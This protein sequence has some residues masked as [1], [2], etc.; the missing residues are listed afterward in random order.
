MPDLRISQLPD[1]DGVNGDELV[2]VVQNGLTVKM[3][4]QQ[5]ADLAPPG[6]SDHIVAF[7]RI[8]QT[9]SIDPVHAQLRVQGVNWDC[10]D[11]SVYQVLW[12]DHPDFPGNS[13]FFSVPVVTIMPELSGVTVG[14]VEQFVNAITVQFFD[15]DGNPVQT[16]FHIQAM[17]FLSSPS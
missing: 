16:A 9:G 8:E 14:V 3:T 6:E 2:P 13:V 10:G 1:A 17:G 11:P 12:A 7:A 5:I 15:T 4:V